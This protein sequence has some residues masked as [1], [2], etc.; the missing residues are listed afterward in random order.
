MQVAVGVGLSAVIG[1]FFLTGFVELVERCY[2]EWVG[3]PLPSAEVLLRVWGYF[4]GSLIYCFLV[5]I[6]FHF[7]RYAKKL[8]RLFRS[9]E[10]WCH[11]IE[12]A[13]RP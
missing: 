10:C 6:L 8:E 12:K 3:I 1:F 13:G 11:A 4:F 9:I 5:F 2:V 7:S